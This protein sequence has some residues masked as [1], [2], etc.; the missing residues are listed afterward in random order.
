MTRATAARLKQLLAVRLVALLLLRNLS[1]EGRLPEVS[2]NR[3]ALVRLLCGG[4]DAAVFLIARQVPEGRHLRARSERLR[5]REPDGNPLL[6]QLQP[7]VFQIRPDLLLI[8]HQVACLRVELVELRLYLTVSD[9]QTLGLREQSLCALVGDSG[10]ARLGPRN[11]G[12]VL[13]GRYLVFEL[14][15]ELARVCERVR[16]AVEA[17]VAMAADA[18]AL[19]EEVFAFGQSRRALKHA[20][21]RVALVAARLHVLL[22]EEREEP[23]LV[24]AVPL[25]DRCRRATVAP[26]AARTAELFGVVNPE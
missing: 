24:F 23:E 21:S 14:L 13:V 26:V 11:L 1:V 18:A 7:N 15:A 17:L 9:G 10:R 20:V 6:A 25:L 4:H 16:F 8:L 5:V 2:R 3:L 19:V 22:R 12:L